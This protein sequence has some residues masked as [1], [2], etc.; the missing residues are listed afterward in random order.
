MAAME[1]VTSETKPSAHQ[2]IRMGT[3]YRRLP[4]SCLWYYFLFKLGRKTKL[5]TF[6]IRAVAFFGLLFLNK[7]YETTHKERQ[8]S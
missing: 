8:T 7:A 6:S 1:T 4:V 5:K 2:F 3:F